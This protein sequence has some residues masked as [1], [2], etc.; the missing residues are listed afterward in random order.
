MSTRSLRDWL[1]RERT[2][3]EQTGHNIPRPLVADG[4][5]QE[6]VDERQQR[7]TALIE[8]LTRD[9]PGDAAQRT[10][11]QAGRWL[12]ANLLDWHRREIKSEWW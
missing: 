6:S 2:S 12:L 3:L 5:P 7:V 1:E 10:E 8:R 11:D 4:A 9:V